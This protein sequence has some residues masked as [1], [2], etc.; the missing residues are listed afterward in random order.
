[1]HKEYKCSQSYVI[2]LESLMRRS[3]YFWA[4][5][6]TVGC[7]SVHWKYE[8]AHES[9]RAHARLC[10]CVCLYVRMCVCVSECWI[11]ASLWRT[12][13]DGEGANLFLC[14]LTL[15]FQT[16]L[17][18]KPPTISTVSPPRSPSPFSQ[19]FPYPPTVPGI[20]RICVGDDKPGDA[21]AA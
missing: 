2:M 14:R 12:R 19:N 1:M 18:S 6:L 3:L 4:C 21:K 13:K 7:L 9:T 17:F 5:W 8:D 11:C 10:A 16:H 20:L 15:S